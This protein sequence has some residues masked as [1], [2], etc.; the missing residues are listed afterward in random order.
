MYFR[1]G[2]QCSENIDTDVAIIGG[3]LA[4]LACGVALSD[5][6]FHVTVIERDRAAGGRACSFEDS[7]TGDSIDIGP[8]ILL[9]EYRNMLQW[10]ER[11]G[12]REQ[13]AW[14]TQ[15]FITLIEGNRADRMYMRPLPAPLHFLPTLLRV[16]AVS[17]RDLLSNR[18]VIWLAMNMHDHDVDRLDTTNAREFLARLGVTQRFIDW[19]WRTVAMTIMNVP[20]ELCSAGALMRFFQQMV[21]HSGYRI[22]FPATSLNAL[23]TAPAVRAIK[24]AGGC[25]LMPAEAVSVEGEG[26]VVKTVRLADGTRLKVR[27]CVVCVPPQQLPALIP[28][29]WKA[30]YSLFRNAASFRPSPYISS[31]IWFSRKLT[32]EPFWARVWA[33]EN[34]NYDSY[35]LSNIR[36]GWSARPSVIAS[37]LIFSARAQ[38]LDDGEIIARTIEE[39]ESFLPDVRQAEV[40][41]AR[42][43]RIPMAIPA[44]LPGS[45]RLRPQTRTPVAGLFLAGDWI[46]T[47]LPASMESA[48]CAGNRA[49]QRAAQYLG[50]DLR[51]ALPVRR[52]EGLAGFVNRWSRA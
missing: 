44:P 38:E 10:M 16:P 4:G 51:V 15:E 26:F 42:V 9:S 13:V 39:L 20:L 45:E 17:M 1:Y 14:H 27:A 11:L 21:G 40:V 43:N 3:G 32:N 36:A 52:M 8:H 30:R 31:Y 37:N 29:E 2:D 12:T 48:V 24:A 46:G 41:H 23:A 22:G 50:R 25:L 7:T 33:P 49:A 19:Y 35:D 6:G 28:A 47:G 5:A 34:L 18:R